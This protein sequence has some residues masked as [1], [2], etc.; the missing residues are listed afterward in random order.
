M[1]LWKKGNKNDEYTLTTHQI[2][3]QFLNSHFAHTDLLKERSLEVLLA[4]F[5][6]DQDGLYSSFDIR[7]SLK[8]VLKEIRCLSTSHVQEYQKIFGKH[9]NGL[10][11]RQKQLFPHFFYMTHRE[12]SEQFNLNIETV[13][14]HSKQ[15][16]KKLLWTPKEKGKRHTMLELMGYAYEHGYIEVAKMEEVRK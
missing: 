10:T 15:I 5:I 1:K 7:T 3:V 14:W 4:I 16:I 2:A 12:I 8:P 9:R 11:P 13:H 6:S